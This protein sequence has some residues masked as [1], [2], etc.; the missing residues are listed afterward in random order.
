MAHNVLIIAWKRRKTC[1]GKA[2]WT[3][4]FYDGLT[5]PGKEVIKLTCSLIAERQRLALFSLAQEFIFTEYFD[6]EQ[7]EETHARQR[8]GKKWVCDR[9]R[10]RVHR[11]DSLIVWYSA[12]RVQ[13]DIRRCVH[14]W[15]PTDE[16]G[17]PAR[18]LLWPQHLSQEGGS[19]WTAW[20][21]WPIEFQTTIRPSL[22]LL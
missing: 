20:T 5:L 13:W 11:F 17:R 10:Q 21:V 3:S 14:L 8:G 2:P 18:N 15:R 19:G 6:C 1:V 12:S 9:P 22:V 16:G 4:R 7:C